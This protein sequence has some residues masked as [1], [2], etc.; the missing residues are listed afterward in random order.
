MIRIFI[1]FF[2]TFNL[3]ANTLKINE[4]MPANGWTIDDSYG[5]SSDWFE[6]YNYGT[7]PINLKGYRVNDRDD[8]NNAYVLPDT[9]IQPGEYIIIWAS[10]RNESGNEV[11][12]FEGGGPGLHLNQNFYDEGS[13]IAIPVAGDFNATVRINNFMAKSDIPNGLF[14]LRE[15]NNINSR[16]SGI[17]FDNT[18]NLY[19]ARALSKNPIES[20]QWMNYY[21]LA[22]TF[23]SFNFSDLWLRINRED[24]RIYTSVS[25]DKFFWQEIAF[26]S[27]PNLN[28]NCYLGFFIFTRSESTAKMQVSEFQ[29]NNNVVDLNNLEIS[30][31]IEKPKTNLKLIKE[32]HTNFKLGVSES[33]YLWNN[34]N[35]LIEKLKWENAY[36]DVSFSINNLNRIVY[37]D[38][39]TPGRSNYE[40]K[41]GKSSKPKFNY[42]S[43]YYNSKIML[44]I[45]STDKNANIY[46]TTDNSVPDAN[47]NMY[48]HPIQIDS[49]TIIR[50]VAI[51]KD[52]IRSDINTISIIFDNVPN[53][54]STVLLTAPNEELYSKEYG[55]L[56]DI[57]DSATGKVIES[58][59]LRKLEATGN[60]ELIN[61]A[62]TVFK[63]TAGIRLRGV[64][65]RH[66][67]QK[68]FSLSTGNR[69][70]SEK[71]NAKIFNSKNITSFSE[72]ALRNAGN[73][74]LYSY[75][76]DPFASVLAYKSGLDIDRQ[77]YLPC[78]V[79]I[80]A[81]YYGLMNLREKTNE[82]FIESNYGFVQ[83]VCITTSKGQP[84]HNSSVYYF[85]MLENMKYLNTQND[86][87]FEYAFRDININ[88]FIDYYIF[89]I[90]IGNYDWPYNNNKLWKN[91]EINTKWRNILYDAD[92]SMAFENNSAYY[93]SYW[94]LLDSTLTEN[95]THSV[96]NIPFTKFIQNSSNKYRFLNR[97]A[98]LLN[99]KFDSTY[100]LAVFDSLANNIKSEM[101]I[102][103]S[104][105]SGS[106]NNWEDEISKIRNFLKQRVQIIRD[107]TVHSFK[108]NG[109]SDLNIKIH[110]PE[111]A[112]FDINFLKNLKEEFEGKYF[113]G[114]P[115]SIKVKAKPGWKF[116]GWSDYK[117]GDST[118][119]E[120]M[121]DTTGLNLTAYFEE[122][123]IKQGEPVI[124]EIMYS[125]DD[126]NDPGDWLELYN[127]HPFTIDIGHLILKDSDD[128]NNYSIPE[129]TLI[130]PDEYIVLA[131]E[132]KNF[133]RIY[134]T[135]ENVFGGFEFGLSND[136][137]VRL[138]TEKSK[139]VDYV[140]YKDYLPWP[141]DAENTG[142]SIELIS[143]QLDNN[144]G[145]NWQLSEEYLGTPGRRN[146][147]SRFIGEIGDGDI[148][149]YYDGF[150][151]IVYLKLKIKSVPKIRIHIFDMLGREVKMRN[152]SNE[153]SNVQELLFD[154]SRLN[155]GL[156]FMKVD[157]VNASGLQTKLLKF[158]ILR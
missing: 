106:A 149:V 152:F 86:S 41:F 6:L 52:M 150:Q 137:I 45:N 119:I 33:I 102:H 116:T 104:R 2:I 124:N 26:D 11:L 75:L 59:V 95:P 66:F 99:T 29:I 91:Y 144:D 60:V 64:T 8:F 72:L 40:V 143:H 39:S 7:E 19:R 96:S 58:N 73:D 83:N 117:Y 16:W 24:D 127:P 49:T 107:A 50:A 46:F 145:K 134:P 142:Y 18:A 84:E 123:N 27:I 112:V 12:Q 133:K 90:F 21:P 36:P 125:S 31:Y 80:N 43:G 37:Y 147:V 61:D 154:V 5:E 23:F 69:F 88:S 71:I 54:L 48:S 57:R 53:N 93:T 97:M 42:E 122:T 141:T 148:F 67:T 121:P 111:A 55:I 153:A 82:D 1:L 118:Y 103:K 98:D 13:Y 3:N 76:R 38:K 100:T 34:T 10:G 44:E 158:N 139:P 77:A 79:Y 138:V 14:M 17:G 63:T 101:P 22:H 28:S 78:R 128:D 25:S 140:N 51:E 87:V 65:S 120:I 56:Y 109:T 32:I 89:G 115:Y 15:E 156:Y 68:H 47:S 94:I 62:G 92:V 131:R 81:E 113:A 70:N 30:D 9:V 146:S 4:V 20:G 130:F 132:I 85:N 129:N 108:L 155:S 35:K 74:W 135:V 151:E 136:D 126:Y 110:P 105:W 157:V 114:V